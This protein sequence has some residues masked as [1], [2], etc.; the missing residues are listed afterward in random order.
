MAKARKVC[1][2]E[3]E[4]WDARRKGWS[5]YFDGKPLPFLTIPFTDADLAFNDGWREAFYIA[6]R[7]AMAETA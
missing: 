4:L 7:R 1:T 3:G 5:A 2:G 6:A